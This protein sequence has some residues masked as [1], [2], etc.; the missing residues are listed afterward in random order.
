MAYGLTPREVR[1]LAYK[2]AKANGMA[3]PS[4]WKSKKVAGRK[5]FRGFMKRN[6]DISIR[7]PEATSLSRLTSFNHP[8]V[9]RFIDNLSSIFQ[10]CPLLNNPSRIWNLDET[11]KVK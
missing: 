7:K 5:W 4:I 2:I 6:P 1:E 10:K 9:K 11:G 8:N 3:M